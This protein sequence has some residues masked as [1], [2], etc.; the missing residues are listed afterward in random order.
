MNSITLFNIRIYANHGCMI[1][2]S[3]I[4]SEYCINLTVEY[5][6]IPAA[7]SDQ[8]KQTVN[9]DQLNQIV[10]KE[11]KIRSNLLENVSY[12]IIKEI[13][14]SFPFIQTIYLSVAKINPPINGN[15]EK[16]IIQFEDKN[17]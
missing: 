4:G 13:R 17:F 15:V 5:D 3:K 9:Y 7:I 11:M 8:L 12:R 2:E 6:L 16:V 10:N 14:C 1:E